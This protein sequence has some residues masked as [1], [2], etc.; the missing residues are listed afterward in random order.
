ML[1]ACSRLTLVLI[2]L[3][4][5]FSQPFS[6]EAE[7]NCDNGVYSTWLDIIVSKSGVDVATCLS[8]SSESYG[9]INI[10]LFE[11]HLCDNIN[12]HFQEVIWPITTYISA[13]IR[14]RQPRLSCFLS[15]IPA[16]H[17]YRRNHV[18]GRSFLF[19]SFLEDT[20]LYQDWTNDIAALHPPCHVT[21][22]LRKPML[23]HRLLAGFFKK[24]DKDEIFST[25]KRGALRLL[26][27]NQ[28]GFHR[29]HFDNEPGYKRLV[30]VYS[31]L[32]AGH[33]R[34][35]VNANTLVKSLRAELD[36]QHYTVMLVNDLVRLS[37]MERVLL[38]D[39]ASVL[40]APHGGWGP[41]MIYMN[42]P[43]VFYP[44]LVIAAEK[45]WLSES[46]DAYDLWDKPWK[47]W[48]LDVMFL[49]RFFRYKDKVPKPYGQSD[50]IYTTDMRLVN[51]SSGDFTIDSVTEIVYYIN[52]QFSPEVA[53]KQLRKLKYYHG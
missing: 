34:M 30:V 48:K 6:L 47:T 26:N 4:L 38:F 32:D 37:N 31:R 17:F 3:T 25:F 24:E 36:S 51:E 40:I 21:I 53:E 49:T 45:A 9:Y 11:T 19:K 39:A 14:P 22:K 43:S 29:D 5:R 12:H 10:V 8:S 44:R 42:E 46:R 13:C 41:N 7:R 20:C 52:R 28:T 18:D 50:T 16:K 1:K 27:V 35:L 23:E 2:S 15:D 33:G